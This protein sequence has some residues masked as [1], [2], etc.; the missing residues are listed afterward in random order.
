MSNGM[1][2]I[3]GFMDSINYLEE[4]LDG[5]IDIEE[6][7][8]IAATSKYLYQRMFGYICGI[9]LGAYI[10]NRRLSLAA[11][12][13]LQ[14]KLS[15]SDAAMKYGYSSFSSFTKAFSAYHGIAPSAVKGENCK[16]LSYPRLSLTVSAKAEEPLIYR[17]EQKEAL[18]LIG[19][20]ETVLNDGVYNFQ[21]IPQMWQEAYESNVVWDIFHMSNQ[22]YWGVM[23]V[24]SNYTDST[25]D[26]H[27]ASTVDPDIP[28]LEGMREFHIPAGR[29]VVFSCY[30]RHR[31]QPVWKRIYGEWF[32][33]SGYEHT[34]G[35]EIEWYS[36]DD[37]QR[38][39]CLTEIWIPIKTIRGE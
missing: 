31:I 1:N 21:R 27:M 34:G 22:T 11:F 35:P 18:R 6:A 8:R 20:G 16:L 28:L 12:D 38:E 36:P 7:A 10:R 25:V 14:G 17:I 33:S 4:H 37:P 26:Y 9:S 3:Q 5:E 15:V 13:L 2:W 24:L 39:D 29:W 23:G 32:P 19:I 30:G